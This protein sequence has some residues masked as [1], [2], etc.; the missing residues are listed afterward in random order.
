MANKRQRAQRKIH[1]R[2]QKIA[3]GHTFPKGRPT[4]KY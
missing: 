1:Q 4:K 3:N 2:E